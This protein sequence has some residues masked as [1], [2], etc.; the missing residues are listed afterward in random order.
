MPFWEMLDA[1]AASLSTRPMA[2]V[3]RFIAFAP[4][5]DYGPHAHRRVEIN[6]VKRGRCTIETAG[7]RVNFRTGELMI[8]TP[9][10]D[11]RFVAGPRG[12]MLMQQ[13]F[14]PSIFETL[15]LHPGS[16]PTSAAGSSDLLPARRVLKVV[17]D[18]E[19]VPIVRRLIAELQHRAPLYRQATVLLYAQLMVQISRYLASPFSTEL[20]SAPLR[21]AVSFARQNFRSS[22]GVDEMARRAGVG[23]RQLRQLFARHLGESP[24]EFVR[25][26]KVEHGIGLLRSTD[27]S[28]KEISFECG[29]RSPQYFSRAF[30]QLTGLS[31]KDAVARPARQTCTA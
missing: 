12:A 26:L 7:E 21:A 1:L 27:R 14:Q 25:R 11:H 9:F 20:S 13:E 5:E 2:E 16:A 22:P 31:P 3:F 4:H 10:A 17:D 29:F 8:I 18:Q 23:A 24:M 6:F 30:K 15:G 28:I 19:I